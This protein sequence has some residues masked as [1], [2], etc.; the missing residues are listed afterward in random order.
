MLSVKKIPLQFILLVLLLVGFCTAGAQNINNP[1]KPGPLGT[2]VNTFSGNFFLPRSDLYLSSRGLDINLTFFYSSFNFEENIGFG[3]GW[4]CLYSIY[5]KND[6][7]GNKIIVWGDARE[8]MYKLSGSN[9][10]AQKGIFTK[11]SQYQPGKF[12]LTQP[13]GIKYYFDNASHKK[14]TKI[15]EPNGN[16]LN[17][18]YTDTI[19]TGISNTAGQMINLAYNAQGNLQTITDAI[20]VPARTITYQYDNAYNLKQVTDPLGS[21][22]KYTYLVNGPMKSLSDK[23]NNVVDIIYYPDYS[24]SEII[25]CNKRQS[26]TYDTT[27]NETT[28]TDYLQNGQNQVTRYTYSVVDGLGWI[29]GMTSNCCGFNMTFEFDKDGNKIKQIDANGNITTYSYDNNGNLLTMTDAL[30]QTITYTYTADYN[31]VASFKDAKGFTTNMI[32]DVKGNL[33]QLIEPGNLIYTTVYGANGDL[34]SSTDPK[35]NIFTYNYDALGNPTTVTGPSGYHATLAYDARGNLLS[36]TDGRNNTSTMEYDILDRMKKITDPINSNVQLTYDAAGNATLIKNKK[37]ENGQLKYDASNRLVQFTDALGNKFYSAYDA[38]DNV[39]SITNSGGGAINFT[40]DKRNRLSGYRDALGNSVSIA[41]DAQGNITNAV[42]PNGQQYTYTYDA[43]DRIKK[44]SDLNGT[45][46]QVSYDKN[47]NIN[48]YTNGTGTVIQ[49]EYDSLDRVKKITDPLGNTIILSFDKN[50]NISSVTDRNGYSTTYTY[51]SLD[52]VKTL[53]DNNGSQTTVGYDAESN[54]VFLKDA[55]NNITT[56]TYDSLNRV[57]RTIYPDG[58]YM[59][60]NYDRKSN[61]TIKRLPDGSNIVY[62]YDSLNRVTAKQLPDGHNFTYTYDAI[63]RVKTATN[64]AGTID[65]NYDALNRVIS[66]SFGGRTINYNYN[67]FGRTQTMTYPDNTLFVK[68]FDTRNRMTGIFRNGSSLVTYQYNN[69]DQL[70]SKTY[71]NGITST[72]QYDNANRLININTNNGLLQNTSFSYDNNWNKTS[73]NRLNAPNKSEQYNYDNSNRLTSYKRGVIGGVITTTNSYT[74]DALGNRINANLNGTNTVYTSNNLNQLINSNNGVQNINYTYDNNGNL[75]YDGKYFKSYDAE[76]RLIK[77]SASVLNVLTYR[78]DAF[79]RRV[80][81][82]LNGVPANF[83]FSGLQQI[84]ERDGSGAIKNK[85]VFDNFLMPVV[86]EKSGVPYYYHQNEMMSVEAITNAEGIVQEKYEY[87]A[88]GKQTIYDGSNNLLSGSNTGNRF[89]FT[90]QVFDSATGTNKYLYREYSPE[91]GLFAQRDLIGYS[92]GMGMYQYVHNNPANGIDVFGLDDCDPP[93]PSPAP[94]KNLA[95]N[96]GDL[97]NTNEF[98][99]LSNGLSNLNSV[100]TVYQNGRIQEITKSMNGLASARKFLTQS[101][102]LTNAQWREALNGLNSSKNA[103]INNPVLKALNGN[104]VG[105]ILAPVNIL[106]FGASAASLNNNWGSMNTGQRVDGA[107]GLS[108]SGAFAATSTLQLLNGGASVAGGGSFATGFGATLTG[109]AAGFT[110]VATAGGMAIYGVVNEAGKAYSGKSIAEIGWEYDVP[111]FSGTVRWLNGGNYTADPTPPSRDNGWKPR[112][113]NCPQNNNPGGPR[114]RKYWYY[115]PNG[116]STEVVQALDPNAILGPDGVPAK[117]WVSVKDVLPYTVLYENDKRATAPAKYVKIEY[118][119]DPKQDP[120]TF[121]LGSYGFNN[122]TFNIPP[123]SPS[124]ATRLDARDSLGL[125]IDVTAGLD[126]TTNKAFWEFQSIDPTTLLPPTNPL[127]GFLMM[128][129]STKPNYGHGFVNFSIKP[130]PTDLTGDTIHAEAKI[131]FDGNDTIPTNYHTNTVDAFA[132]TSH[133]NAL[134]ASSTNPVVLS[135]TGTDDP[136]G[137]GI[138]SYTLYVSRDGVNFSIV[139]SGITRT[140]TSMTLAPDSTYCFFVLATDSVGN[141]E[142]ARPGEI[143]CVY[144][145]ITLPVTWL[146]FKGTTQNKDNLL[147]WATASEQNSKEF[148]LE[149]SLNSR[150][151]IT[152]GTIAAAGNSSTTK[153][154]QYRDLNID[155]LNSPIMY[156]RLKQFDLNGNFRYSNIV[157]LNYN[158]KDKPN[159]IIY[160]NPTQGW[161]T[162]AVGDKALIGSMAKLYD[163]G[164][165]Q[166]ETIKITANTQ[167]IN[168]NKYV[169]GVYFIR[170]NNKEVLKLIKN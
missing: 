29:T 57:K 138:K 111:I 44:V 100:T 104:L 153:T 58:R 90:G 78:Y 157:R 88:Y 99:W 136:G 134:P 1:N 107:I 12:L 36:F 114:K 140:D 122:Q 119:V 170:L 132:P 144:V 17:F 75:T 86:N 42:F 95:D 9:Y 133:M 109:T 2:Q 25:G 124:Y 40:Y 166:L 94:P 30:N 21:I 83:T 37:G 50:S 135:W 32:Y 167:T 10:V 163:E 123:N 35:G 97:T 41:Y 165:R 154:Y 49:F 26:F 16:T 150:D 85:T 34:L 5:Y 52:R 112:I 158:L 142:T 139:R 33:I 13:D 24:V 137:C 84:E 117:K 91:T 93:A 146:Y 59:E 76:G 62:T 125:F 110:L 70:V 169:N 148:K 31:Q 48:S 39:T 11:L 27:L 7:S 102:I 45:L 72:L 80:Q 160:P 43:L 55:N 4:S 65:F 96:V 115:L 18:T 108:G 121:Y 68:T 81:K 73:V 164:G 15:D 143:K 130:K 116:D 126:V 60:Y 8:D 47:N 89:G 79:G 147:E 74:Y 156:Y 98:W 105:G 23:N 56:Y 28:I 106:G 162:I 51:D 118:P 159:T 155:R 77:D 38:M 20:T 14:V 120:G 6:T 22:I 92:D 19:L 129:D 101:K 141:M 87:D 46:A 113:I 53:S 69:A 128:Q 131:V 54:V 71:A 149:R 64:N 103:V 127:A 61:V 152:I 161:V 63:G 151:F 168:M 67:M 66:E 82:M 3:K 145:G